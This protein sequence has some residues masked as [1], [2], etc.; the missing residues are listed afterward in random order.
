MG[1]VSDTFL[2]EEKYYS[3]MRFPGLAILSLRREQSE[4]KEVTVARRS[5]LRQ[6]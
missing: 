2:L 6:D 1:E 4:S 5:S 3:F